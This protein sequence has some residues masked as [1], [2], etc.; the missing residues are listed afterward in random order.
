MRKCPN[1]AEETIPLKWMIFENANGQKGRCYV[2]DHCGERIKKKKFLGF[3]LDFE[4]EL[5]I[6]LTIGLMYL[7]KSL[8]IP[9]F[10]SLSSVVFIHIAI[11]SFATLQVSDEAYC[12]GD[13]TKIGAFFG[14]LA[15]GG[16]I[17][18][19]VYFF[20]IRPFLR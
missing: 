18:Y 8:L 10:L 6:I 3:I 9:F 14:L 12:R 19:M 17:T 1:C 16:I 11:N 2:C 4:F 13:M 5:V 15:M 20:V 7:L